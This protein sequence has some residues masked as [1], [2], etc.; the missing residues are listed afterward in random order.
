MHAIAAYLGSRLTSI[1][2]LRWILT[3]SGVSCP[4]T[5]TRWSRGGAFSRRSSDSR[6]SGFLGAF[7]AVTGIEIRYGEWAEMEVSRLQTGVTFVQ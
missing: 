7:A 3:F 6:T 2:A 5:H 4:T 1:S